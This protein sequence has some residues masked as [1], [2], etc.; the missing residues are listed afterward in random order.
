MDWHEIIAHYG[1]ISIFVILGIGIIGLPVPDEVLL[2]YL[3][4]LTSSGHMQFTLVFLFAF[5]GALCGISLSYLLGARL[6]EPFLRKYGS[7]LLI[8]EKTIGRANNLFH[9]Y[10]TGVLLVCYFIPGVRHVA[11]YIAGVSDY[12][13]RR[14]AK[15]AY[16]GAFLWVSVF[17]IIG[18]RLGSKWDAVEAHLRSY[19]F[20]VLAAAA[21]AALGIYLYKKRTEQA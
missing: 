16:F 20:L 21:I 11:A 10:G 8:K 15:I 19:G 13:Y 6:G 18:N 9:K 12:P 14:F 3:G 7:K 2:A 1:Y 4:F 5:L 17:L